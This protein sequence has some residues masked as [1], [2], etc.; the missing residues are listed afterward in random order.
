MPEGGNIF[1]KGMKSREAGDGW[2]AEQPKDLWNSS[3]FC[4]VRQED[5]ISKVQFCNYFLQERFP[6]GAGCLGH[7]TFELEV[8]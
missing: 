3:A 7:C 4:C 5:A 2:K 6:Y 1:P 8:V